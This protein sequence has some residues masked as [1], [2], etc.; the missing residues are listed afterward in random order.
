MVQ[1]H[2]VS[3]LFTHGEVMVIVK[4]DKGMAGVAKELIVI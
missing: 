4:T 2:D 3:F 1:I